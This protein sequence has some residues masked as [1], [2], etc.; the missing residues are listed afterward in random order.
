MP[1][2]RVDTGGLE[3]ALERPR[4]RLD[5]PGRGLGADHGEPRRR[6]LRDRVGVARLRRDRVLRI[7]AVLAGQGTATAVGGRLL[8][9]EQQQAEG[10]PVAVGAGPLLGQQSLERDDVHLRALRVHPGVALEPAPAAHPHQPQSPARSG[11]ATAAPPTRRGES[12]RSGRGRGRLPRGP[13]RRRASRRHAGRRTPPRR[14]SRPAALAAAPRSCRSPPRRRRRA[15]RRVAARSRRARRSGVAR[16]ASTA[17]RR[18]RPP[19]DGLPGPAGS[20]SRSRCRGRVADPGSTSSLRALRPAPTVSPPL[21]P[22]STPSEAP[23]W[24]STCT[25]MP[26]WPMS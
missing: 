17:G 25:E 22:A 2:A 4:Q 18:C 5:G 7:A 20:G 1:D 6:Q 14:R 12:S 21:S 23:C 11:R 19:V 13:A 8:Q 15:R 9:L 16:P 10:T 26:D 24:G 3:R